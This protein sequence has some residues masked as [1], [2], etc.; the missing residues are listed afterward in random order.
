MGPSGGGREAADGV[1]VGHYSF[2]EATTGV[3]IIEVPNL[4]PPV[5]YLRKHKIALVSDELSAEDQAC[6]GEAV[7]L[8]ACGAPLP[9]HLSRR[10]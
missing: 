2:V 8:A 3:R 10:S 7:F 1:A 4:E 5:I 9:S 6:V